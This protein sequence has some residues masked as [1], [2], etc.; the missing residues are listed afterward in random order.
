MAGRFSALVAAEIL[1][2]VSVKEFNGATLAD[3]IV[4][5]RGGKYDFSGCPG[6]TAAATRTYGNI[7]PGNLLTLV[8]DDSEMNLRTLV[9]HRSVKV[10]DCFTLKVGDCLR[11][12]V[13]LYRVG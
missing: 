5:D 12:Y 6:F 7:T 4:I 8:V 10:G 3:C 9:V 1:V 13:I 2:V 11:N